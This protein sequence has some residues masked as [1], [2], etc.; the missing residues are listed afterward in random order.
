M[1]FNFLNM[2]RTNNGYLEA[3]L[4]LELEFNP[5]VIKILVANYNELDKI[6]DQKESQKIKWLELLS[7]VY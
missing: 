4:Y 5:L 6:K 2:V 7:S 1:F 3:I